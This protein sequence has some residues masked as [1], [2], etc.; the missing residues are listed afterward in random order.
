MGMSLDN[1]FLLV[2]LLHGSNGSIVLNKTMEL[3]QALLDNYNADIRPGV[4]NADPLAVS[5]AYQLTS[6]NSLDAVKGE[7]NAAG[8]LA[9]VWIEDRMTWNPQDYG[10]VAQVLIPAKKV[11][12]HACA[13]SQ[14]RIL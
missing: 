5:L 3:H 4:G 13:H 12:V 8:Y 9:I 1:I 14:Q 10:G 2:M 7:M 11:S 6:L